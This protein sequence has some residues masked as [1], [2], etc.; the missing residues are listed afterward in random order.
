MLREIEQ[1][2]IEQ[3]MY[4]RILV[5]LINKNDMPNLQAAIKPFF[6]TRY[7]KRIKHKEEIDR[8][9]FLMIYYAPL[10]YKYK[11]LQDF[12]R[13]LDR[14]HDFLVDSS[15]YML[16]FITTNQG[17]AGYIALGSKHYINGTLNEDYYKVDDYID[18]ALTFYSQE[19]YEASEKYKYLREYLIKF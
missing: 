17:N 13:L 16:D 7:I 9:T 2:H 6:N 15:G 1:E 3:G 12:F 10:K 8:S 19:D 4:I 5:K 14:I 11:R 18:K